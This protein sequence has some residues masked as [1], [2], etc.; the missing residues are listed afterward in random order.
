MGTRLR[1]EEARKMTMLTEDPKEQTRGITL[2]PEVASDP[3]QPEP[4]APTR[5]Q[6]PPQPS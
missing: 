5:L 1:K 6:L 4:T 3:R 2:G